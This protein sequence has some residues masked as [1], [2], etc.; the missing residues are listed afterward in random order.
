MRRHLGPALLCL[1]F[2]SGFAVGDSFANVDPARVEAAFLRNFAHYVAWPPQAFA[3]DKASWRV[4]IIGDDPFGGTLEATLQGRTEQGRTF[5]V[6]R[7][8][9]IAELKSCH[10]AYIAFRTAESRRAA[11]SE[12]AN[13]PVLTVGSAPDFLQEGGIVRF[14]VSDHVEFAVNLDRANSASLRIPA[15]VLEVAH[16]VVENGVV[17]RRR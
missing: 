15:K 9:N 4:C 12:L 1:P 2:L 7:L 14:Q 8:D 5:I 6:Q 17:R 3:D 13:R 10:L 16:E 11:L